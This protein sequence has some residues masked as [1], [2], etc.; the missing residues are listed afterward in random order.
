MTPF[1]IRC[2][3]ISQIMTEPRSKSE[4]LSETAKAHLIE[5][6]VSNRYGRKKDLTN[7]YIQKGLMVEEDAITLLALADR[8]M[9]RKNERHYSDDPHIT[10]TPDI[11]TDSE[12]IDVKAAWDLWTFT[13][14]RMGDINPA[15]YWQM[16]GYMALTGATS[17]RVVHCLV[18]TPDSLI[19]AEKR[20]L[21][22]GIG[23]ESPDLSEALEALEKEM[24]FADI[25]PRERLHTFT[26]DRNNLDIERIRARV[27]ACRL[28]ITDNMK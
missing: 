20:K 3:A 28:W 16:Q 11:V 21:A 4:T 5:W 15:Y 18:D 13:K 23:T 14:A 2:S 8:K 7:R 1:K 25:D 12:V 19:E 27:E 17:A 26:V 22:Y 24:T 9:Y 10:G 6:W